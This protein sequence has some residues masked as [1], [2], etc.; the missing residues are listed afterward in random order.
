MTDLRVKR[1]DSI[2]LAVG[3]VLKPDLTPQNITGHTLRFTGKSR[4]D[5]DDVQ[6]E[7][8]G[9]TVGGE[10]TITDG[11]AGLAEVVIPP[12]ATEDFESTRVFHWDL[13]I[14]D[15]F[16]RTKTLDSGKLIVDPDVT[17][18]TP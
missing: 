8:E 1:G 17:R 15:P 13:Q 18:T 7:I 5:L 12:A 11:P 16:G 4:L 2:V 9:S 6:A 14:A 10:I 3:P